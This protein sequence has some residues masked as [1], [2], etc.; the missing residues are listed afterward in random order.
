MAKITEKFKKDFE[1]NSEKV[2]PNLTFDTNKLEDNTPLIK[3]KKSVAKKVTIIVC[4]SLA[5]LLTLVIVVPVAT[6]YFSSLRESSSVKTYQKR[7]S[8]NEIKIAENN[9]FKKLN[10][11]AYPDQTIPTESEINE[12]EKAAYN[13]FL[14][15]T[16]KAVFQEEK[17]NLSYATIGLY[18]ILNNLEYAVSNAPIKAQFNDLLGLNEEERIAFY[19]KMMLANSYAQD[20]NTIQLKN[21]AFFS[22]DYVY[23]P[24]YIAF[25]SK[26]YSEAYQL[27]FKKESNK[28]VEW[29]NQAVNEK[30]F[31]DQKFLDLDNETCLYLFSTYY[32]KN[33]WLYKYLQNKNIVDDFYLRNG[34]IVQAEYMRHNFSISQYYDYDTYVSFKDYYA[35]GFAS[36]TYLIPKSS[37]DD[38]LELTKEANI[39]VEDEEKAAYGQEIEDYPGHYS[40]IMVDLQTPKFNNKADLDFK[41]ALSS[42]GFEDIYNRGIN[43]FGNAFADLYEDSNFYL[44]TL[45]Q[46]NAVTFNED[47]T[48][49]KSV[50]MA[51]VGSTKAAPTYSTLE[52]KL[53][54]PFIYI[55]RDINDTPVFVGHL[56]NPLIN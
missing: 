44:Q 27:D 28:I 25:L 45:K 29:V 26:V 40:N 21:S 18:S 19:Q 49:I 9:S 43:T 10:N 48:T 3:P 47:G 13:H 31:I 17:D 39:F 1:E 34:Q 41:N 4:S 16:Y 51:E 54:Q 20:N 38:I 2:T 53:N 22:N 55:I 8:I 33:A 32:F 12:E 46:R 37:S 23:N 7:Y 6:F 42:L 5:A 30:N 50:T 56:D 35:G 36:I 11:I 14:E 15:A 24:S 52:V